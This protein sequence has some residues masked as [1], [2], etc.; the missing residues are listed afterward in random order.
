[1]AATVKSPQILWC[2]VG[3]PRAGTFSTRHHRAL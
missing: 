1:M 2:R 3:L